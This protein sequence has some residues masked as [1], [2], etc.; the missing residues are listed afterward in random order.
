M[1]GE[2]EGALTELKDCLNGMFRLVIILKTDSK[3]VE[4]ERCMRGSDE[5]LCFSEKE[6]CSIIWKRSGMKKMIGIV[7]W[8]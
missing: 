4:G 8:K 5:K 3:E 7:M 6:R 2:A 1:I